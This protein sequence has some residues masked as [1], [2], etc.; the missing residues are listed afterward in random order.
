MQE[1]AIARE[2]DPELDAPEAQQFMAAEIANARAEAI[3]CDSGERR[4]ALEHRAH[5]E[6][7][8]EVLTA[9]C[10][11]EPAVLSACGLCEQGTLAPCAH[12][13]P[14]DPC[15]CPPFMLLPH[16]CS[17]LALFSPRLS[18]QGS[19]GQE[20]APVPEDLPPV[21][22]GFGDVMDVDV[23]DYTPPAPTYLPL[24]RLHQ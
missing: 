11:C 24:V 1:A 13:G 16:M 7:Q 21:D 20:A 14:L 10:L 12:R 19:D 18:L 22:S 4:E 9:R 23:P 3:L 5:T 8:S 17:P 6:S 15:Q 2:G